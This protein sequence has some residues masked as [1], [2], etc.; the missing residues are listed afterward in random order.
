MI[1]LTKPSFFLGAYFHRILYN[2]SIY[3]EDICPFNMQSSI[4][5]NKYNG[6]SLY[7]SHMEKKSEWKYISALSHQQP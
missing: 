3:V 1:S 7:I 5:L 6:K 2:S 4:A